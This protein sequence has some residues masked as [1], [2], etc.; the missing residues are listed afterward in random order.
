MLKKALWIMIF[1]MKKLS[2]TVHDHFISI[3]LYIYISYID[4][5][6]H[7]FLYSFLFQVI[8]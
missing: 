3:L 4:T 2:Q 5:C 7:R 1:M 6:V 8:L